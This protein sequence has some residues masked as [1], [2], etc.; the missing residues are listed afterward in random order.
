MA[1]GV[2]AAGSVG[3]GGRGMGDSGNPLAW[4]GCP[5]EGVSGAEGLLTGDGKGL[6]GAGPGAPG[7]R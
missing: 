6:L 4:L 1:A 2:S 3:V 7:Q 5:G